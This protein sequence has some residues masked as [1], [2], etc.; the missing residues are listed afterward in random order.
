MAEDYRLFDLTGV[1]GWVEDDW[2]NRP[3]FAIKRDVEPA[4]QPTTPA[5]EPIHNPPEKV[6][7]AN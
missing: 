6:D 3:N 4:T 7:G 2:L 1:P 5:R